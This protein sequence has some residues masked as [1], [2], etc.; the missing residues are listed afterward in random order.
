MNT[1]ENNEMVKRYVLSLLK[2]ASNNNLN[3]VLSSR[4]MRQTYVGILDHDNYKELYVSTDPRLIKFTEYNDQCSSPF[5][6]VLTNDEEC[7]VEFE[8]V[9]LDEIVRKVN[10]EDW[11]GEGPNNF[12]VDTFIKWCNNTE[13]DMDS[14]RGYYIID[15]KSMRTIAKPSN[16]EGVKYYTKEII[17]QMSTDDPDW[18]ARNEL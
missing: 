16:S 1:K 4:G 6:V 3:N 14:G 13:L 12:T 7:S 18:A 10:A 2:E 5:F 15:A 11:G 17:D 9:S 8:G